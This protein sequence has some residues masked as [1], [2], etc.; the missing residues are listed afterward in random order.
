MK[1]SN[2]PTRTFCVVIGDINRSRLL[3][4]RAEVQS[5]F[6]RAIA[7][8]NKEFR[9][10]IRAPFRIAAGGSCQGVLESPK[11][12]YRLV[13]RIEE[14]LPHAR[15]AFGIGV[16]T[17]SVPPM[18][19][20]SLIRRSRVMVDT[21][22]LDGEAFYRARH[23]LES[24]K[25]KKRNIVYDYEHQGKELLNILIALME[26]Q[27]SRL[28]PRQKQITLLT[29]SYTQKK[30]VATLKTSQQAISKAWSTTP[31]R[32]MNE[33]ESVINSFLAQQQVG[34]DRA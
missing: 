9:K 28:T 3:P 15:I 33:A 4:N 7:T 20:K 31:I 19:S 21:F 16:G 34:G 18:K 25:K 17:L 5:E 2:I 10:D 22:K 1:R 29:K 12:S 6:E 8:V 13:R 14:L 24:A 30:V 32:E 27:W 11:E 23:A 26:K